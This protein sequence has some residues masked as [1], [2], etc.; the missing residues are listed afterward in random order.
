M[1]NLRTAMENAATY[2]ASGDQGKGLDPVRVEQSLNDIKKWKV[3]FVNYMIGLPVRGTKKDV[4]TKETA[5]ELADNIFKSF[6]NNEL[7]AFSEEPLGRWGQHRKLGELEYGL[8]P[9]Y[10]RKD[11]ERPDYS[12]WMI[13][14][15]RWN[16]PDRRKEINYGYLLSSMIKYPQKISRLL[17]N[18]KLMMRYGAITKEQFQK[19]NL[20]ATSFRSK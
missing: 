9:E 19:L 2:L 17:F 7:R 1:G 4:F 8:S 15:A 6:Y 12:Q 14:K 20:N 5:G 3:S 13:R 11:M 16:T 10:S 18:G